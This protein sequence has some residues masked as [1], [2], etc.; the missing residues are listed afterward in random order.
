MHPIH[1]DADYQ[2]ER[3]RATVFFRL[4][5]AIPWM[6]VIYA[7]GLVA[8]LAAVASWFAMMFTGRHP[9]GLYDFLAGFLRFSGRSGGWMLLMTDEWPG[10]SPKEDPDYPIEITVDPPQVSYSRSKTFFKLVLYFPQMLIG[11]GISLIVQAAAFV[12]WWRIVFTGKQSATMHDALRVS[13]AYQL[14]ST[15]F[16]L[17]LTETHPRMLDLPPQQFPVGTPALPEPAGSGAAT[18]GPGPEQPGQ[19]EQPPAPGA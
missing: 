1:F 3:N 16:L 5:L 6:I 4:L 2:L 12:A 15:G 13:L 18:L 7:W 8:Y 11:Y 9:V 10:F 14:R 17:L 19:P